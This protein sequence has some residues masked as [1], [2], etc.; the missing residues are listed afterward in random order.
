MAAFYDAKKKV[1]FNM[2]TKDTGSSDSTYHDIKD[3]II[4]KG[5]LDGGGGG[6]VRALVPFNLVQITVM[7]TLRKNKDTLQYTVLLQ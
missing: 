2:T 3:T 6:G 4:W 1:K 7:L 5:F